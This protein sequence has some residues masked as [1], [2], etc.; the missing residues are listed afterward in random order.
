LLARAGFAPSI[1]MR[2]LRTGRDEAEEIVH[3]LREG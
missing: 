2:A 3:R 1:A